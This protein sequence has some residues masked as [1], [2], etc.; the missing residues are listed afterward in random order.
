MTEFDEAWVDSLPDG[1]WLRVWVGAHNR[2]LHKLGLVGS[3]DPCAVDK[4]IDELNLAADPIV[5]GLREMQAQAFGVLERL[6]VRVQAENVELRTQLEEAQAETAAELTRRCESNL[7]WQKRAD[8]MG[9]EYG[10][11]R[12]KLD[13]VKRKLD[14]IAFATTAADTFTAEDILGIAAE[15]RAALEGKET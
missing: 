6:V 15:L 13:A 7:Y 1:H 14:G 4:K 12:R 2:T 11:L 5:A 8:A 10:E 9:R 3:S